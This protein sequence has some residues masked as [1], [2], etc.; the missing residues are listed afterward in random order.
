MKT[1]KTILRGLVIVF[2]LFLTSCNSQ[3]IIVFE[4]LGIM[5]KPLPTI[6]IFTKGQITENDSV[7]MFITDNS[8]VNSL[9]NYIENNLVK[10]I[11]KKEVE[12]EYGAYKVKVLEGNAETIYILKTRVDSY[13]FFKN[14]IRYIDSNNKLSNELKVLLKRLE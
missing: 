4:P 12:F 3:S 1:L 13:D 7:K 8:T 11:S 14:Q 9:K 2:I 10:E 6:K 5:D